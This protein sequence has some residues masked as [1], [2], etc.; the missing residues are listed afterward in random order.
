MPSGKR[1][2]E[3]KASKA[4]VAYASQVEWFIALC[5]DSQS[6]ALIEAGFCSGLRSAELVALDWSD[7][8]LLHR[9]VVVREGK[10][11]DTNDKP[12]TVS[13]I[14]G[15]GHLTN[16]WRECGCP[17][18]GPVFSTSKGT[19]LATSH[20]RRMFLRLSKRAGKRLCCHSLR[21]GYITAIA[22]QSD[23]QGKG[24]LETAAIVMRQSRHRHLTSLQRYFN[25]LQ[26]ESANVVA[27]IR[28]A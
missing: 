15:W 1:N 5:D 3:N 23:K 2:T 8:D 19:R 6:K 21:H 17:T 26:D 4:P 24:A 11:R 9:T 27:A 13:M 25:G 20:I 10:A 12:E 22:K 7:L 18:S 14:A 16:W 28:V